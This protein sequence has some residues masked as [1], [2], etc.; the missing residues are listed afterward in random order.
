MFQMKREYLVIITFFVV[1]GLIAGLFLIAEQVK[2]FEQ[3]KGVIKSDG[4][5]SQ[6][7]CF[8]SENVHGNQ[9]ISS[10]KYT[11]TIFLSP[12]PA[13]HAPYADQRF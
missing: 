4:V 13:L 7:Y 10:I 6:D 5:E 1:L 8:S 11:K 2:K 12:H 9:D 3:A